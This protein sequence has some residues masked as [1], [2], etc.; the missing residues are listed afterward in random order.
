MGSEILITIGYSKHYSVDN[1]KFILVFSA[2][3]SVNTGFIS[4]TD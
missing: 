4:V 2:A 1:L 3:E